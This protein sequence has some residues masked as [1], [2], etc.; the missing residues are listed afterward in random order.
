[1]A[2]FYEQKQS[3]AA[4]WCLRLAV[5]AVPYFIVTFYLHRVDSISTQQAFWLIAIG[6]ALVVGAILL[7]IRAAA[8]LWEK[9]YSG[10]RKTVNGITLSAII[11]A[12]FGYQLVLAM[13][14]PKL[15]DLATDLSNPPIYIT[16]DKFVGYTPYYDQ[17]VS[18]TMVTGYPEMASRQYGATSERVY[19]SV[20]SILK[21][22]SWRQIES[23][24]APQKK[25]SITEE[26][27]EVLEGGLAEDGADTI[28]RQPIIVQA[29][30]KSLIL[31]LDSHVLIRL[32]PLDDAVTLV[33]VRS[34]SQWG[35]HDFGSNA[36][37][38]TALLDALD[39]SLAGVA[40]ESIR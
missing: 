24:N 3:Q 19:S 13:E 12:P 11:L 8:D 23:V 17:Y 4:V 36:K 6:I 32:T 10:G 31:K 15:N 30:A 35:P 22:W 25:E 7:G 1:M 9:G 29:L 14:H 20:A 39:A 37:N 27:E 2:G 40:G 18:E 5:F 33:D 34:R 38:I 26:S 21:D 28:D 16:D